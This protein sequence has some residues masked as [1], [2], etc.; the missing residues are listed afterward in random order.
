MV[1]KIRFQLLEPRILLD[2]AGL[3]TADNT[4]DHLPTDLPGSAPT[5]SDDND[6][7]LQDTDV[8]ALTVESTGLV[9]VDTSIEGYES[10]LEGLGENTEIL[11]L[12]G[13]K[14]GL[15]QIAD[16]VE[17]RDDISSIHILSHGEDGALRLGTTVI[18]SDNL[19]QYQDQLIAIGESLTADGDILIYGCNVAGGIAGIDFVSQLAEVTGADV[20]A[21]TDL[22]G[23]EDLGG[24]W[25]LEHQSG[26]IE[27]DSLSLSEFAAVLV[28]ADNDAPVLDTIIARQDGQVLVLDYTEANELDTT[29]GLDASDFTV[30]VNGNANAV[31]GVSVDGPNN[32]ITLTLTTAIEVGDNVLVSFSPSAGG[33]IQDNQ[34]NVAPDISSFSAL[35]PAIYFSSAEWVTIAPS[36][37]TV[38]DYLGDQQTGQAGGDI[39]G[40]DTAPAFQIHFDDNGS[41][42]DTDGD[43]SFRWRVGAEG[44]SYY[45]VGVDGNL[46]GDV[47]VFIVVTSSGDVAIWG[48]DSGQLN[49]S[50]STT[51]LD[52]TYEPYL[53]TGDVTNFSKVPVTDLDSGSPTDLDGGGDTDYFVSITIP[54]QELVDALAG[55]ASPVTI[56]DA[57]ALRYVQATAT[58]G[59]SFNQ[60]IGGL[61]GN[62]S[63][64]VTYASSGT[65]SDPIDAS[66]TV[67]TPAGA[68][69]LNDLDGDAAEYVKGGGPVTIDQGTLA[70]VT[71]ADDTVLEDPNSDLDGGLRVFIK[72]GVPTEDLLGIDTSLGSVVSVDTFAV[73]GIVSVNGTAVGTIVNVP[74]TSLS[75]LTIV[76]DQEV[77]GVSGA[78]LANVNA[79][80]QA[81][82]YDNSNTI[83][84]DLT[85]RDVF[86]FITDGSLN[87]EAATTVSLVSTDRPT[88]NGLITNDPQPILSGT[89]DTTDFSSL[90]VSLDGTTY[91]VGDGHLTIDGAGN[92]S[93]DLITTPITPLTDGTYSVTATVTDTNGN[94]LDDATSGELLVDTSPPLTPTVVDVTTS[95]TTPI[96]NGTF[97]ASDTDRLIINVNGVDYEL[98]VD[99]EL[100]AVGDDWTL[101]LGG[102]MPPLS[103]NTS[104]AVTATAID[105]AGNTGI[106]NGSLILV[107]ESVEDTTPPIIPTVD[108]L[109]T[110]NVRPTITGTYDEFD[111]DGGIIVNVNGVDYELGGSAPQDS[112]LTVDGSGNWSLNLL[113]PNATTLTQDT[114]YDVTVTVTDQAGNSS[115]DTTT[116]EVVVDNTGP[117]LPTVDTQ[118]TR[119]TS[120]TITGTY[121]DTDA[122]GGLSVTVNGTTYELGTDPEL[123]TLGTIWSLALDGA[124]ILSFNT[125]YDVTVTATDAVNNS[126]SDVTTNELQIVD[127]AAPT[128]DVLVTTDT[129]PI[130][131]GT[132]AY[133]LGGGEQLDVTING[134]NYLDVTVAADGTWGVLVSPALGDGV[135]NVDAVI[136]KNG[137]AVTGGTDV[138]SA[139]L[140]IDTIAPTAPTIV[141]QT[142]ELVNPIVTGQATLL[143]GET[144]T[145][146]I[147]G[148]TYENVG[149]DGGG[150]WTVD[151]SVTPTSGTVGNFLNTQTYEVVATVTDGAGNATSDGTTGEIIIDRVPPTAPT[152]DSLLTTSV[153]PIVT[154]TATINGGETL[155]VTVDGVEYELGGAD[156]QDTALTINAGIWSLDFSAPN[157][158]TLLADTTYEVTA[159]VTDAAGLSGTDT[160]S[161]ELVID[162]TPPTAPTVNLLTT[163][164]TTPVLTGTFDA[165]DSAS[166]TVLVDMV[167]YTLGD[168][169]LSAVGDNW[170]L[171][172]PAG[173]EITPD[174]TYTVEVTAA[175]AAGN[176]VAD[177]TTDE[178]VI[179]ASA[180]APPTV[181]SQITNDTTPIITGTYDSANTSD[182]FTVTVN[183]VTY[184]L[185]DPLTPELTAV[186]ND[187]TLDLSGL[188]TPLGEN[189]YDVLARATDQT[190]DYD[191]VTSGELVI[192]TTLPTRPT[193]VQLITADNTP[194]V[195]GTFDSS[196]AAE[197]TVTV[198]GTTYTLTGSPELTAVG[199]D[200]TLSIPSSLPDATYQLE[201]YITDAAGNDS[202]VDITL[203]DLTIDATGPGIPTVDA[204]TTNDQTPILTGSYDS[205]EGGTLEVTVN[206]VTYTVGTDPEITTAGNVW[207]LDLSGLGAPLAEN[208]YDVSVTHTDP[209]GVTSTDTTSNELVIDIAE[210][211]DPTVN[212]I[213][214]SNLNPTVTGTY[215]NDDAGGGLSVT[216]NGTTYVLG[217]DPQLTTF[218]NTW[219]VD[220]TGETSLV[221]ETDY[222]VIVVVTDEAG[223]SSTDMS[224]D[225]VSIDVNIPSVDSLTTNQATP[226]VTGSANLGAG[227]TLSASID[228]GNGNIAVYN[229][230]TVDGGGNWSV[231]SSLLPDSGSI[232][233]LTDGQYEVIATISDTSTTTTDISDV[234]ALEITVDTIGPSA[235]TVVS[236]TTGDVS[237][238]VTGTATLAAGE[239]L[240]VVV[241]GRTYNNVVVDGG[242]NW[243]IDTSTPPDSGSPLS[244]DDGVT[245]EVTAT[246]SDAAGNAT[247]DASTGE[248]TIDRSGPTFSAQTLQYAEN[249]IADATVGTLTASDANG[250]AGYTFSATGTNTSIDGYFQVDSAGVVMI[251]AAGIAANTNDFESSPNS[252]N[253]DVVATDNVGNT[254]TATVTLEVTDLDDAS[255]AAV[256]QSKTVSEGAS[257]EIIG[258]ADL[259]S[260]DPDTDD[261]TLIYTVGNVTNGA[262]TINGNPWA[263]TTNDTFTQQ[264][265]IDGNVLYTHDGSE[266]TS[267]SFAYTIE[268]PTGN[269]LIGQTFSVTVTPVNDAPTIDVT[270]NALTEDDAG[271]AVGMVVGTYVTSDEENDGLTVTFTNPTTH[272]TL[273]TVN[274][275]VELTAAGLAVLNA[276][277]AL[278]DIELTV[279]DDGMPNESGMDSAAVS[280]TPFDDLPTISVA[281]VNVVE[282]AAIDG[283]VVANVVVSDE[284]GSVSLSITVGSD[285]SGYYEITGTTVTLTQD[286]A[287]HVN[288]NGSLPYEI[289]VTVTDDATGTQTASDTTTPDVTRLMCQ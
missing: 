218:G 280:V 80:I 192:D 212:A 25:E 121:D 234:T 119:N 264:D 179:N 81:I 202:G 84:P 140:T 185:G 263:A 168:G 223:N 62:N 120:P 142:T 35:T 95:D 254:V 171:N 156:P 146:I 108:S 243:S 177:G 251:T 199:D 242:G 9:V 138:T 150:N 23:S 272:Y 266:T 178:L 149:V 191:D 118:I 98:G 24:D 40:N 26:T 193:V 249:Q 78:T 85:D 10:L 59:N 103:N 287:D 8:A 1:R 184:T 109:V 117:S 65:F 77:G 188:G 265:I 190:I 27:S 14:D 159:V 262:L 228:E 222:D 147:N 155:T 107:D 198:N 158:G 157:V 87:D 67:I 284:E 102:L 205:S 134:V 61:Q 154:G 162:N 285:P 196:D 279:T 214:T 144:L 180:P 50:P 106:D 201:A 52:S 93:L 46:D 114:T 174:G 145:V 131:T 7:S 105:E 226:T 37:T 216:I 74:T 124:D 54:F 246:V 176:A 115:S 235:P 44:N 209:L 79:I 169:N 161:N 82:T 70:N 273:D 271:N 166:L 211:S 3:V 219:S 274:N 83:N 127:A 68:P 227:D 281:G 88:V 231:D 69:M 136:T 135:Y 75:L 269:Q 197:L 56:T 42:S 20:A 125:T 19:D 252:F 172:I 250:I 163:P 213:T 60:D 160:T 94:V 182:S 128:V 189:T 72:D 230:V 181:N 31:T 91:T 55:L 267:D 137:V 29:T 21:S 110:S 17:G 45:Y 90:T 195:V 283:S 13:D 99:P 210:P 151:T 41:A 51:G 153:T 260:T 129:T 2:A 76:F 232:I 113:D 49:I 186:A 164:D 244:F 203:N 63:A 253:H 89:Y 288:L 28:P 208:P 64:D 34:S 6:W 220:L 277:G 116:N 175:D 73:G 245:Y 255:P 38:Y 101:N 276:G 261:A 206:G 256:N 165:A 241:N 236:Q 5:V 139:E 286:G 48:N 53:V 173:N 282:N 259:Q 239:S 71:D 15:Q 248:I 275:E 167:L 57:S 126:S 217:T 278:D 92:W 187:W 100:T 225:E 257:N 183:S 12:D 86:F 270:A 143:A 96:I 268:D 16:Y 148:G 141:S 207:T 111:A 104:Y 33:A 123:T 39:V 221:D 130:V 233:N 237:P 43:L 58:Q 152:V 32:T 4:L 97:Q 194:D 204:L 229:N 122:A 132:A 240:S 66:G 11:L 47:D 133:P 112:A 258:L 170:T 30:T 36:G 238:I 200:W 215:P 247:N 22:T 18:N 289:D 224:S